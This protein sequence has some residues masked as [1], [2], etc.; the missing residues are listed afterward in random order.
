MAS[1]AL[2]R[3]AQ[4]LRFIREH[5][6][7]QSYSIDDDDESK[8]SRAPASAPCPLDSHEIPAFSYDQTEVSSMTTP[9][10]T[11][12][13]NN[14]FKHLCSRLKRRLTLTK[15]QRTR[16]EDTSESLSDRRFKRLGNYKTFSSTTNQSIDEIPWPDFEKLYESI[17]SCLINALPGLNDFTL[18]SHHE[19]V[20][21][22]TQFP[23]EPNEQASLERME[24]FYQCKRGK[25]FRRNAICL[26]L[27]KNQHNGQLDVFIQQLMVEKLM[28]TWT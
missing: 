26:K 19:S 7:N 6:N 25:N 13:T 21:D 12:T 3:R 23:T 16:S 17:P 15:E 28:R 27:D 20:V 1:A 24:E 14:R 11:N 22:P 5:S 10:T 9:T 18:D 8:E 2:S 4:Y